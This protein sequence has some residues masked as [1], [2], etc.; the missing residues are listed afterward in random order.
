MF[1]ILNIFPMKKVLLL[2]FI[3]VATTF[4]A[5]AQEKKCVDFK[6]GKFVIKDSKNGTSYITRTDKY[7]IESLGDKK[8]EIKFNVNWINDCTYELTPADKKAIKTLKIKPDDKLTVEIV[9]TS[10]YGYTIKVT[11]NY[12]KDVFTTVVERV[13]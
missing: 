9:S 11:S 5:I 8:T 7:Q 3:I 1:T 12:F 4:S 13:L 2:Y 10:E 6:T